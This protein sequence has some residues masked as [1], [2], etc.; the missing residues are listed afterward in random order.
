MSCRYFKVADKYRQELSVLKRRDVKQ[1][2]ESVCRSFL[3]VL[4]VLE[5]C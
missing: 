3:L 1:G 4:S 2:I 5:G